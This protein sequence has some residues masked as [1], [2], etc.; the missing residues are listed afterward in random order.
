M[1]LSK[2]NCQLVRFFFLIIFCVLVSKEC[3]H[4]GCVFIKIYPICAKLLSLFLLPRAHDSPS[5]QLSKLFKYELCHQNQL[6]NHF[7]FYFIVIIKF[8]LIYVS[9]VHFCIISSPFNIR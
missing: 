3:R 8:L 9:S 6:V 4:D 2:I 7:P 1:E 5:S